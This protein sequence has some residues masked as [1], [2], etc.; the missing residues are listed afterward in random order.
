MFKKH[1]TNRKYILKYNEI[2]YYYRNLGANKKTFFNIS[3]LVLH[4]Q[5]QVESF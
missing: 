3:F 4:D 1:N 5:I 2:N